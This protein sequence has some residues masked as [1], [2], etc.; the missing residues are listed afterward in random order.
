M[1]KI[2]LKKFFSE[3][4]GGDRYEWKEAETHFDISQGGIF[5]IKIEASAKAGKQNNS[6]D[7]DDLRLALDGFDFG[8]YEK[9]QESLSWKGFG[10]SSSW[11]GANL[12]GGTKTVYFFAE[13]EAGT[14][15]LQFF[16]DETPILKNIEVF[17][18]A[19]NIFELENL[20]PPESIK[21]KQKGVP[22]MSFI[23][24]GGQTKM[25]S[26]SV[27]TKSAKRKKSTDGDNLKL[28]INGKI[29]KNPYA[30]ESHKYKNFY[31]S[32]DIRESDLF[33]TNSEKLAESLAFENSVDL[34]YD[35]KPTIS[36]LSVEYFDNKEFLEEYKKFFDLKEYVLSRTHL[37]ISYFKLNKETYSAQFLQHALEN[38]PSP[39][40]FD[41][42]H[43]L[44]KKLKSDQMYYKLIKKI[45]EK[46][47]AGDTNGEIWPDEIDGQITFDSNDLA[48]A[49]HGI[50][51]IEYIV[52]PKKQYT[53]EVEMILFDVY[54]FA[55]ANL[56]F[57]LA[58]PFHYIKKTVNNII[59]IGEEVGVIHNFEIEIHISDVIEA[60][61][62]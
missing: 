34:W 10:T 30:S 33:S 46:I 6:K 16:A 15:T 35:E 62:S 17:E 26:L 27:N 28:I 32:G 7:D 23:F 55:K 9:H 44:V 31:F 47:S 43:K 61:E 2:F 1:E 37:A 49:I 40:I 3:A 12:R 42:K 36:S 51:K 18:I 38:N 57:P 54:D 22:W 21:V 19:D 50:R 59:D 53:Y 25:F 41:D 58:H 20:T 14:H 5:V 52:K 29:Q 4:P 56:P 13:L 39:L 45:K 60:Y 48:T 11:D 8:K 24:L